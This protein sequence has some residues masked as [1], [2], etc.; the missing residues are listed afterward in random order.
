MARLFKPKIPKMPSG[1]CS[2]KRLKKR[3]KDR[4]G[5][6]SRTRYNVKKAAS[7]T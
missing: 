7:P 1:L 5:S 3:K 4:S 2:Q 6:A